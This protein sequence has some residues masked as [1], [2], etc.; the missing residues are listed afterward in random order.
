MSIL[1]LDAL[2]KF[3]EI[4]IVH[5]TDC[6]ALQFTNEGVKGGLKA[7]VPQNGAE[8]ESMEFGAITDVPTGLIDDLAYLKKSP[9]MRKELLERTYGFVFDIK[10]GLLTPMKA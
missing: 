9:Y 6:G 7:R 1:A 3:S 5:H 4:M 8:I 2:V 10:T